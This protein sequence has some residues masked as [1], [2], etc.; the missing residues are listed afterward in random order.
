MTNNSNKLRNPLALGLIIGAAI[1]VAIGIA[2]DN[3][4]IGNDQTAARRGVLDGVA[5]FRSDLFR[6]S[7]KQRFTVDAAE[8]A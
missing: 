5:H 7:F 8:K 1:G 2:L 3:V 6:C 4:A